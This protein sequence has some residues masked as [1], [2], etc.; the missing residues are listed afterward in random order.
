MLLVPSNMITFLTPEYPVRRAE[1]ALHANPLQTFASPESAAPYRDCSP[2]NRA[3]CA[4]TRDF[5]R[6]SSAV[7]DDRRQR[8]IRCGVS[9]FLALR[10][11]RH[12]PQVILLAN[13]YAVVTENCVCGSD[14]KIDIGNRM[15][16]REFIASEIFS[17]PARL[18]DFLGRC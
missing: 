3:P 17:F 7:R 4:R 13:L 8:L 14:M 10:L 1:N 5:Y 6:P 2:C 18:R 15:L 9:V 12:L 16:N 11:V